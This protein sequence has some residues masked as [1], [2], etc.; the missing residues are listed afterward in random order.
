MKFD[1]ILILFDFVFRAAF[2]KNA[3][4]IYIIYVL[5][6]MSMMEITLAAYDTREKTVSMSGNSGHVYV[7][8]EWFN[9]RV[10]ILLIDPLEQSN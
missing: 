10:K 8:A 7:P 2:D 9:K 3:M 4:Y 6:I 5:Y 1:Y